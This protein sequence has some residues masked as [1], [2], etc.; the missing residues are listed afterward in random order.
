MA[1]LVV[2]ASLTRTLL[3]LTDLS[4]NVDGFCKVVSYDPGPV[5]K[6]RVVAKSP[7]VAG[8]VQTGSV[9]DSRS[10]ALILRLY[11]ATKGDLD[12]N[13]QTV[14]DAFDQFTYQLSV[15]LADGTVVWA[16]DDAEYRPV[17]AGG[18]GV[19]QVGLSKSAK[20]QAFAFTIPAQPAP[21]SGV[22]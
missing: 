10:I 7:T 4:L 19:D 3:S 17:R 16:C 13:I 11:G 12:T 8:H 6:R 2:A 14:V 22:Y 1:D 15:Q 5:T 21:V 18:D 9:A 20:W